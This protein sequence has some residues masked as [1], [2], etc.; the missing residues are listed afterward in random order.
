MKALWWV[1]QFFK[2]GSVSIKNG[3]LIDPM[4]IRGPQEKNRYILSV[5]ALM[6]RKLEVQKA[7]EDLRSKSIPIR[8]DYSKWTQSE[9]KN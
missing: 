8:P 5:K 1:E 9:F 3:I 7:L 4:G 2:E 6:A